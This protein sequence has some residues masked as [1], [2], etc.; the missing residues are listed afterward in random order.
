[1][2]KKCILVCNAAACVLVC[3]VYSHSAQ[4]ASLQCSALANVRHATASN[5][6]SH[7]H[8]SQLMSTH[9]NMACIEAPSG[10]VYVAAKA[11]VLKAAASTVYKAA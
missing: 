3:T 8:C 1:M 6:C 5:T 9:C 2:A 7:M 11:I 10:S 4:L